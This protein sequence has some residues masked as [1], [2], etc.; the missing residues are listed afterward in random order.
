MKETEKKSYS[1]KNTNTE[2]HIMDQIEKY[3]NSKGNAA[4]KIR[5]QL[6]K[7]RNNNLVCRAIDSFLIKTDGESRKKVILLGLQIKRKNYLDVF[8]QTYGTSPKVIDE[9]NFLHL[10]ENAKLTN[11]EERILAK[12]IANHW[13]YDFRLLDYLHD[14]NLIFALDAIHKTSEGYILKEKQVRALSKSETHLAMIQSRL[15]ETLQNGSSNQYKTWISF[16]DLTIRENQEVVQNRFE[17]DEIHEQLRNREIH[18]FVSPYHSIQI[19]VKLICSVPLNNDEIGYLKDFILTKV[20]LNE[21]P[22]HHLSIVYLLNDVAKVDFS[23]AEPLLIVLYQRTKLYTKKVFDI[24]L[25]LGSLHIYHELINTLLSTESQKKR[26]TVLKKLIDHYPQ[27][28]SA[29]TAYVNQTHDNNLKNFLLNKMETLDLRNSVASLPSMLPNA[30]HSYRVLSRINDGADIS[31]VLLLLAQIINAN[32]FYVSVGFVFSSGLRLLSPLIDHIRNIN[33]E[34]EMIA[35]SLQGSPSHL[36]TSKI[37]RKTAVYVN[38]LLR[39][40]PLKLYTYENAFYHGKFYYLA[41]S[42]KAYVVVGSSNISKT[43]YYN[44]VELDLLFEIDL[45][46]NI[47]NPFLEWYFSFRNNCSLLTQLDERLYSDFLWESELGVFSESFIKDFSKNELERRIN[48][49]RDVDTQSRL[50]MWV[51]HNPSRC[52][53]V[54]NIAALKDYFVM[55]F[56]EHDIAVFESFEH[57]N[58]FY[59][60]TCTNLEELILDVSQ[61]SKTKMQQYSAYKTRGIHTGNSESLQKNIDQLFA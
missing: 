16:L 59:V 40:T 10:I 53:Y 34:F 35:G 21:N 30:Y 5:R 48:D 3:L 51:K 14:D 58:A 12:Y 8:L 60:F 45:T 13:Q 52:S 4:G 32:V 36:P 49:I 22:E 2:Q 7:F 6:Q 20:K 47:N 50:K 56:K 17:L 1:D 33:G 38:K 27:K 11:Q 42:Q 9:T 43:A 41:N 31:E 39:E 54:H 55:E 25:E 46:K 29:I 15:R 61:M 18:F 44:N 19:P 57:G 37:N 23:F 26:F 28:Y 24:L